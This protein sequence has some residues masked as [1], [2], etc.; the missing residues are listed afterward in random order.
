VSILQGHY[1]DGRRAVRHTVSV[2]LAGGRLRVVGRDVDGDFDVKKV[3]VSPRIANTPRWLY[4]PDGGACAIADNDFVDRVTRE[5]PFARTL[6]KWESRPAYAALAVVMVVL[7]LWLLIDRG[8][9]VAVD[10]VAARIPLS[11]E[12]ALGRESLAGLD[13]A[14]LRPSTLGAA[15]QNALRAKFRQ[16]VEAGG[17]PATLR[18]EFR[19]SPV[20]GPNA[21]ALPSGILVLTDELVRLAKNDKEILAV[22][23]HEIG[24]VHHRH[25]MRSLLKGSATALII[26]GVTGDIASATSLAAAAPALLLQNR[27]S[28]DNEREADQYALT[29]LQRSGIE[30]RHFAAILQRMDAKAHKGSAIPTFLSSHPPTREREA[31][32]LSVAAGKEEAAADASVEISDDI[33]PKRPRLKV[34]E[35]QQRAIIALLE[36]RNYEELERVLGALQ[37]AFEQEPQGARKLEEA[38]R[39]FGKLAPGAA[40]A[41]N[42]WVVQKPASYA[43][44]VARANYAI[45]LGEEARG[46]DFIRDTAP[47]RIERMRTYF[48]N[49][50]ADLAVSLTLTPKPYLS[51]RAL[52]TIARSDGSRDEQRMHYQQA[53]RYAPAS[54]ETRLAYM[55]TLEP[56]WGGSIAQ[57]EALVNESR[58]VLKDPQDLDRIA[59]RIPAYRSFDSRQAKDYPRA[60]AYLDES[61]KL[62]A[63]ADALCQRAYVLRMLKRNSE[64]L[65]DVSLALFKVRDDRYCLDMA[66]SLASGATDAG[67]AIRLMGMVIEVDPSSTA[68]LNQRGWRYQAMGKQELAFADYLASA[69]LGDAWAQRHAGKMYWSGQGVKEDREEGILWLRKAAAQGDAN[70]R[71]S[72]EQALAQ[73]GRK[74]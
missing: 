14:L 34:L 65:N 15:R 60:L 71:L 57:M 51:H 27:Y 11:A 25:S 10:L 24:H 66:A 44:R 12:T 13:R 48:D 22:L 72:L 59:A 8:L 69:T 2:L 67:E 26:A 18:L 53:V 32:A 16:M 3:R 23:A 37:L 61:V 74:Q 21:F 62:Y 5:R 39:S 36:R 54:V 4:L 38:F 50:R 68:A 40:P 1:F 41:L 31:L 9:P 63:S 56:R 64:A 29:L 33:A 70:A 73:S 35:P 7:G 55:V 28:R 17:A 47:E 6:H 30:P 42:E 46:T 49:A 58:A 52:L 45:T 20:I 43:A 19:A